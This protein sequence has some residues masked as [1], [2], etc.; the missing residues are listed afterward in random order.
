MRDIALNIFISC[1]QTIYSCL[2]VLSPSLAS[3]VKISE[4]V[5]FDRVVLAYCYCCCLKG[6]WF[7]TEASETDAAEYARRRMYAT[8]HTKPLDAVVLVAR[9][10]FANIMR[11]SFTSAFG[12]CCVGGVLPAATLSKCICIRNNR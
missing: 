3:G 12:L 10:T 11:Y 2:W 7:K 4:N 6:V 9:Q 1:K 5:T 8:K